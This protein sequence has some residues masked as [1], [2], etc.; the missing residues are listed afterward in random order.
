MQWLKYG[1]G[2]AIP[3]PAV[4]ALAHLEFQEKNLQL[5]SDSADVCNVLTI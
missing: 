4:K 1:V 3:K 2:H 5:G